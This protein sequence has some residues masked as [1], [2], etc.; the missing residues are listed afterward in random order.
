M[1]ADII[2]SQ[3]DVCIIHG[4]KRLR[5]ARVNAESIRAGAAVLLASLAANGESIIENVY[6]IDRGHEQIDELLNQLGADITRI[7][8]ESSPQPVW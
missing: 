4:V 6:Q 3:S 8:T 1:G 7:E 2:I 5:P